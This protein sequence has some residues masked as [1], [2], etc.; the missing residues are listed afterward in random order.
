M[1]Q[2]NQKQSAEIV[3]M[4][5]GYRIDVVKV[6]NK[7]CLRIMVDISPEALERARPSKTGNTRL[8]AST[9]GFKGYGDVRVSMN[10]TTDPID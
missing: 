4:V 2:P 3:P 6:G 7:D 10:V 5:D 9:R 1:V 8:V